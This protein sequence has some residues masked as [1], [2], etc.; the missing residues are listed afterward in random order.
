MAAWRQ[1]ATGRS[2]TYWPRPVR[3][4]GSSRRRTSAPTYLPPIAS[5]SGE[6]LH[7]VL[8]EEIDLLRVVGDRPKHEVL[9][10][11]LHQILDAGVDPVDPADH[12]AL[13][14]VLVRAVGS[15]GPEEGRPGLRQ[16]PLVALLLGEV[17]EVAV[18]EGETLG[19]TADDPRVLQELA[20]VAL[21]PLLRARAAG[22]PVP[23]LD[24]PVHHGLG[25]HGHVVLVGIRDARA[26]RDPDHHQPEA[27]P[28]EPVAT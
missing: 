11:G 14:Q 5:P 8:R 17:D 26:A 4:R 6:A 12:V 27:V 24:D 19:V 2:S 25:D 22:E 10:P 21:D 3:S 16:R 15:H 1:P 28:A 13:L 7:D 20:P 23:G 18:A 9:E